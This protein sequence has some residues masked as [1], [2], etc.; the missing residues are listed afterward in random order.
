MLI[1]DKVFAHE[2]QFKYSYDLAEQWINFTGLPFVFAVWASTA[3][4]PEGFTEAFDK[5]LAF[6]AGHIAESLT[7][8]LPCSRETAIDY[9]NN[10]ISYSLDTAK[11]KGLHKFYE[12]LNDKKLS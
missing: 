6:G 12:L 4:L 9:L 5:A 11:Q 2:N 10:N 7:G 3:P 8:P 1:G